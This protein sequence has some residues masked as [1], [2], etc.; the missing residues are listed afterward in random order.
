MF[1]PL[2]SKSVEM[3]EIEPLFNPAYGEGKFDL[4]DMD[5]LY[6]GRILSFPFFLSVLIDGLN[7]IMLNL[8][9]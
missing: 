8:V 4:T 5:T 2:L 1:S 9:L 7:C 3:K 6:Y